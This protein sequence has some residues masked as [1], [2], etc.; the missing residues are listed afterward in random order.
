F[1]LFFLLLCSPSPILN[2]IRTRPISMLEV[3][4]ASVPNSESFFLSEYH[5]NVLRIV[6]HKYTTFF[7]L[8][9]AIIGT[10]K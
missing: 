6:V 9:L 3:K 7:T 4:I 2:K 1:F 8:I 5:S 10:A